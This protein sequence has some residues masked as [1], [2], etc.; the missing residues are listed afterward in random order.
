MIIKKKDINQFNLKKMKIIFIIKYLFC[1]MILSSCM[2]PKVM[3]QFNQK[4]EINNWLIVDDNVMGGKSLS[5]FKLN[6]DGYGVFGGSI[7][8]ENNGGFC[9]VRYS[10]EKVKLKGN[11]KIR[12][13][14]LGDGKNYQFRIKSNSG[15]YYSYI[16]TFST[17]GVW[18]ETEISLKD[19]YPSFRGRRLDKPNFSEDYFEEITFLIGNKKKEDFK[20]MIDRI[21]LR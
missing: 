9:S 17:S 19:M 5:T 7:S 11:S 6:T 1:F 10:F 15:D 13:K 4:S 12:I 18:Q 20:L 16:T 8:L 21:E 14:L 2:A 3:F